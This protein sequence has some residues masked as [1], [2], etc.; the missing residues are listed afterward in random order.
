MYWM[1]RIW[2]GNAKGI[3]LIGGAGFRRLRPMS[4][5]RMRSA[6]QVGGDTD[7]S[8]DVAFAEFP[9]TLV[10]KG[11]AGE[12]PP[13]PIALPDTWSGLGRLGHFAQLRT[14]S[15]IDAVMA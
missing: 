4:N 1:E 11:L 7:D 15:L 6:A 2:S 5:S 13:L 12:P 8:F 9:A 3:P 10:R 14:V